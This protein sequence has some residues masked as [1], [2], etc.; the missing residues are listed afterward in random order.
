[1]PQGSEPRSKSDEYVWYHADAPDYAQNRDLAYPY[2]DYP[3][4]VSIAGDDQSFTFRSVPLGRQPDSRILDVWGE[5]RC[6]ERDV[7]TGFCDAYNVNYQFQLVS[8]EAAQGRKLP[9]RIPTFDYDHLDLDAYIEADSFCIITLMGAPIIQS[10]ADEMARIIRKDTDTARIVI[11]DKNRDETDDEAE[12]ELLKQALNVHDFMELGGYQ[13]E[14]QLAE[15][16]MT[17]PALALMPQT[18]VLGAALTAFRPGTGQD[19]ERCARILIRAQRDAA[20]HSTAEAFLTAFFA[21]DDVMLNTRLFA[22]GYTLHGQTGGDAVLTARFGAHMRRLITADYSYLRIMSGYK[23]NDSVLC[24]NAKVGTDS[25]DYSRF[26]TLAWLDDNDSFKPWTHLRLSSLGA[27]NQF[28]IVSD[29]TAASKLCPYRS[30]GDTP[31]PPPPGAPED[32]DA[33]NATWEYACFCTDQKTTDT[34]L[35]LVPVSTSDGTEAF[36]IRS[37][38]GQTSRLGPKHAVGAESWQ[39]GIFWDKAKG[40]SATLTFEFH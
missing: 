29:V 23:T 7:V 28:E 2:T 6:V 12:I 13:P 21:D 16:R 14:G 27:N 8:S 22:L 1:M 10:S 31:P 3:R 34:T 32:E 35:Y 17:H 15:I 9:N 37:E 33:P 40:S 36:Q 18:A 24:L 19:M 26:C 25:W 20:R 30:V 5:G 39:Y 4:S 38:L 11:Y